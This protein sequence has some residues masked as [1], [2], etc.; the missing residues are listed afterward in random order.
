MHNKKF[1]KEISKLSLATGIDLFFIETVSSFIEVKS[2]LTKSELRKAAAV[3]KRIKTS[4]HFPPQRMNP[5]GLVETPRPYSLVFAYDG[6][7]RI[8]TVLNWLKE[9]SQEDDYR[10]EAL[11]DTPPGERFFFNHNFV[12]GV[13]LLG[14]GYVTLDALPFASHVDRAIQK[15]MPVSP[16]EIWVWGKEKELLILWA[17]LNQINALLLWGEA[18]LNS[19]IG[20]V[21]ILL[22][23]SSTGSG[24]NSEAAS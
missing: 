6:P 20:S 21:E 23:D 15:G 24:K 17:L 22:D 13:F 18:D 7:K 10:L 12:D 2:R 1:L 8:E 11:A 3:A 14:R 16:R 19:Y 4:A 9:I 5:T